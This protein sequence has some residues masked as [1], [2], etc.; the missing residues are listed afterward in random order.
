M[1]S[2][3]PVILATWEAEI[4]RTRIRGHHGKKSSQ[5]PISKITRVK[6]TP[7]VAQAVEHLLCKWQALGSNP[8]YTKTNK[9]QQKSHSCFSLF[10]VAITK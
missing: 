4:R 10:C 3:M 5:D 1:E 8:S 2:Q 6:W 9:Q 7:G